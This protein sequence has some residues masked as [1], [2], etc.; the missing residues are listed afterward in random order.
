MKT[1]IVPRCDLGLTADGVL[2]FWAEAGPR[3]WWKKD[4]AFDAEI[5]ERFGELH[6]QA[7]AGKFDH[8]ETE[9]PDAALALVIVLDQFSRHIHRGSPE[10]YACDAKAV[11]IVHRV[12]ARGDDRRMRSDVSEFIIMPLMHSENLGDQ[13]LS[14]AETERTQ[15]VEDLKSAIGHR[16]IILRFGRFPHRNA[17]LG[18]ESTPEELEFLKEGVFSG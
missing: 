8:W 4:P 17:I 13:N 2:N 11:V 5:S 12:I 6:K 16:D 10:A 14:V 18:R 7:T 15:G 9:H 1:D 3:R